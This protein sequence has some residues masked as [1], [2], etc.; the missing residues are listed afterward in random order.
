MRRLQNPA[1]GPLQVR[2]FT[3]TFLRKSL[4]MRDVWLDLCARNTTRKDGYLRVDA[5]A[6]LNKVT[7]DIIGLAGKAQ[8]LHERCRKQGSTS[9][10][11]SIMTLTH[12]THRT[13]TRMSSTRQYARYS[14][15][16]WESV[17]FYSSWF[18][19][20]VIS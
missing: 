7:L 17:H 18:P 19:A 15:S 9:D 11:A 16:T 10:Q 6:W 13:I 12:Y 5:F 1:F 4:E 14:R 20:S 3:E 2:K 8:F